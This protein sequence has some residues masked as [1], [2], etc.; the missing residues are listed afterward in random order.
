MDSTQDPG[1]PAGEFQC[2]CKSDVLV[3]FMFFFG[4]SSRNTCWLLVHTIKIEEL[5]VDEELDVIT[6]RGDHATVNP[7]L[8]CVHV[9]KN[10]SLCPK[11]IIKM[12]RSKNPIKNFPISASR[13]L[14]G[15]LL[16]VAS[17]ILEKA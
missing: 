3:H 4:W 7:S 13:L 6:Q 2:S 17:G 5:R 8:C 12:S 9:L 15:V 14:C 1:G 16:S 10:L 11:K